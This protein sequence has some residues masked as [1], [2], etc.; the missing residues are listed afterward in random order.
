MVGEA[1]S[2]RAPSEQWVDKF[3]AVYTPAVLALAILV[4]VLPPLF[5]AA[6]WNEWVYRGLVLLVIGCPCALVISTP[7][8]I[9]ASLAAAARHGVLAKGGAFME[10]PARLQV[11]ALDKTGTLTKGE[12]RVEHVVPIKGYTE[13]E[14]LGAMAAIEAHTR[15]PACTGDHGVRRGGRRQT[16]VRE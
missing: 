13:K 6:S 9:V 11:V 15:P 1:Q 14:L 7:V 3:A 8:S 16:Q 12:P 2:R 4:A 5:F 10:A